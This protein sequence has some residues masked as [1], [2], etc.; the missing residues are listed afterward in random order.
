MATLKERTQQTIDQK[1]K[2]LG[3][4]IKAL[5]LVDLLPPELQ[6]L[7]GEA[8]T[9]YYGYALHLNFYKHLHA[10]KDVDTLKVARMAGVTGLS[11]KMSSPDSWTATGELIIDGDKKVQVNLLGLPKPPT[12]TI[13]AYEEV[14]TKY[15]A[16]CTETGEEIKV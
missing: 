5:E 13:E 9:G 10:N 1:R 7:E 2:S 14:V 4:A 15:K 3:E 11:P 12:C 6:A 8:D 16:I